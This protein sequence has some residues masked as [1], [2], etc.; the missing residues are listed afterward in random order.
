MKPTVGFAIVFSFQL[1]VADPANITLPLQFAATE[2]TFDQYVDKELL[3]V[4]TAALDRIG[5]V[6]EM[7]RQK[8]LY[9]N[10]VRFFGEP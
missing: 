5:D 6:T 2:I 10:P 1:L 8:I 3:R 4:L 9:D 7:Q